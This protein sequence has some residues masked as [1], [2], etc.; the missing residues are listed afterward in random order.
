VLIVAGGIH[1]LLKRPAEVTSPGS[2]P[3]QP[4]TQIQLKLMLVA[5]LI[6]LLALAAI[7]GSSRS[8]VGE[9]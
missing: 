2:L 1:W 5:C 8:R 4:P 9:F 7:F 3:G 6:L